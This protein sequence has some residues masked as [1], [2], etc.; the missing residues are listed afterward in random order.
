MST[1]S[2]CSSRCGKGSR[3]ARDRPLRRASSRSTRTEQGRRT[4]FRAAGIWVIVSRRRRDAADLR[5]ES[6]AGR[7]PG[8]VARGRL[9]P[10]RQPHSCSVRGTVTRSITDPSLGERSRRRQTGGSGVVLT[11][12][13]SATENGAYMPIAGARGA[14][15]Q[16]RAVGGASSTR[17]CPS[18]T[19]AGP[20]T[21]TGSV[22]VLD[23]LSRREPACPRTRSAAG[24][25]VGPARVTGV[26]KEAVSRRGRSS[27][28]AAGAVERTSPATARTASPSTR[29]CVTRAFTDRLPP[30]RREGRT[31][32]TSVCEEHD[33]D[34]VSR[35]R[36]RRTR[37]VGREGLPNARAASAP[38]AGRRGG[39]SLTAST[40]RSH[41]VRATLHGHQLAA[42]EEVHPQRETDRPAPAQPSTSRVWWSAGSAGR[43]E[44]APRRSEQLTCSS[45]PWS[46][47]GTGALPGPP[48]R[49]EVKPQ[50]ASEHGNDA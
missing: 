12:N 46:P 8:L 44:G 28:A 39:T 36:R 11:E 15:G 25:S 3:G 21:R 16:H 22:A 19:S 33:H 27:A 48:G 23:E 43:L 18:D 40:R 10:G 50:A 13:D 9:R 24:A 42:V 4:R 2:S 34:P 7:A 26:E 31:E 1:A 29:T 37:S 41:G 49:P 47:T 17:N 5:N 35:S 20:E 6:P 32:V 38:G 14:A 30:P 45:C